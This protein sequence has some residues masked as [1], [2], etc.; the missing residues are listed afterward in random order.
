MSV[1]LIIK[2]AVAVQ[3]TIP[4]IIA[5]FEN[6]PESLNQ[7]PCFVTYLDSFS[8]ERAGA[9]LKTIT[10]LLKMPLLVNRSGDLSSADAK[11]KPYIQLVIDTFDQ[12]IQLG[13]NAWSSNVL[14]G[15]YGQIEYSG[16]T[17]LG[18][19]FVLQAQE[20]YSVT[21]KA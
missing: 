5:A 3:K 7:L 20:R 12:N 9:N 15:K 18:I 17:Y 16:V 14:S 2:G 8:V 21:Y 1:E 4:G 19:D 11:L 10:Y 13:G 6:A